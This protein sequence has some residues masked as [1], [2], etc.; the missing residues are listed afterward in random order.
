M[1]VE[2]Q[3]DATLIALKMEGDHEPRNAVS[4]I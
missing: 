3:R 2:G 4:R 1:T